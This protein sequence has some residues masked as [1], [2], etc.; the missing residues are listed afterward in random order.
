MMQIE[1]SGLQVGD[2]RA[3]KDGGH[4]QVLITM[5]GSR[6]VNFRNMGHR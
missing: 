2:E 3:A 4:G 5:N 6:N 1:V